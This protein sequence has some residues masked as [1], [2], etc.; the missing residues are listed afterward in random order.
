MDYPRRGLTCEC[1]AGPIVPRNHENCPSFHFE[2]TFLT[3]GG[4]LVPTFILNVLA[5]PPRFERG[6]LCLEGRCSIHLSYGR[7][8]AYFI[9]LVAKRQAQQTFGGVR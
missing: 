9:R 5:R 3:P 4:T 2:K 8:G 7:T 1:L 6:T